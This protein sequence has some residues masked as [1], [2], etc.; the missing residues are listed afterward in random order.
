MN[1]GGGNM[2]FGEIL[3]PFLYGLEMIGK[4]NVG[5]R[6][7]CNTFFE[8]TFPSQRTESMREE[9]GGGSLVCAFQGVN[10]IIQ[11]HSRKTSRKTQRNLFRYLFLFISFQHDAYFPCPRIHRSLLSHSLYITHLPIP[12]PNLLSTP[13]QLP[14]THPFPNFQAGRTTTLDSLAAYW[15]RL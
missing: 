7:R 1:I 13:I 5:P 12:S 6:F 14:P 4:T 2:Q 10:R 9:W 3:F 15:T 11:V 8:F